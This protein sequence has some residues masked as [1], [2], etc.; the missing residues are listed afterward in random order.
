[1]V[2]VIRIKAALKGVRLLP[3]CAQPL[4]FDNLRSRSLL[5]RRARGVHFQAE[6]I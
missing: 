5:T 6:F 1:M 3:Q 4:L 2:R